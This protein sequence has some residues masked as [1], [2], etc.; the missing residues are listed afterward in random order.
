MLGEPTA[1]HT[2]LIQSDSGQ[3]VG[4]TG[5][6]VKNTARIHHGG[7]NS[8]QRV[9]IVPTQIQKKVILKSRPGSKL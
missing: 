1:V 4:S 9:Y 7:G 6:F 3:P 2:L 5:S 8:T